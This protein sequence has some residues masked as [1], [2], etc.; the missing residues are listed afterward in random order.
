MDKETV[1]AI[2]SR[3]YGSQEYYKRC[4]CNNLIYTEGIMDFQKT[5]NAFWLVE[6]V[7]SHLPKILETSK[8]VDDGFFVITIKVNEQQNSGI[9]EVYREGLEEGKYN[10]HITILSQNIPDI[11]LPEY[12]YKFYLILTNAEPIVFTLLLTG[13]Y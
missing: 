2:Y 5:L 6:C 12:D 4:Y 7:I 1:E 11:D 8:A 13:E 3:N 10:E 9:F